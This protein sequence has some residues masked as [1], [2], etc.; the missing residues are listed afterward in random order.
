MGA[1][2][3]TPKS[4]LCP[5]RLL[6]DIDQINQ[7]IRQRERDGASTTRLEARRASLKGI[8]QDVRRHRSK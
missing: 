3:R 2:V 5:D 8:L 1:H 4:F 7:E 6:K